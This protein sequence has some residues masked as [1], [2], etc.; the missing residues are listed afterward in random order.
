MNGNQS[1]EFGFEGQFTPFQTIW[2]IDANETDVFQSRLMLEKHGLCR[3]F[4]AFNSGRAG[5]FHLSQTQTL[6]DLILLELY[7]PGKGG[8]DFLERLQELPEEISSKTKVIV[9]TSWLN[10]RPLLIK[11]AFAFPQ[12]MACLEKPLK[13]DVLLDA[14]L[15]VPESPSAI[16]Y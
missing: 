12:V 8:I 2:H 14:V 16:H 9:L 15:Q 3:N 4:G 10:Y 5:I 11:Q 7:L 6:P 1:R 13:T